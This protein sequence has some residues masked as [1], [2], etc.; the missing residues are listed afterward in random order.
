MGDLMNASYNIEH[1]EIEVCCKYCRANLSKGVS[2]AITYQ[3]SD[4]GC[5]DDNGN[6][7][8]AAETIVEY[9][10]DHIRDCYF[11]KEYF[12]RNGISLEVGE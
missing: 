2:G 4:G 6:G 11:K 1:D 12:E 8:Y 10:N 3:S 9:F 5:I 7:G